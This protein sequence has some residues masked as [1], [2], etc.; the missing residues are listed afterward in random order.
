MEADPL[1]VLLGQFM[2]S[3][4]EQLPVLI[5]HNADMIDDKF[6]QYIEDKINASNDLEE[7]DSLRTLRDAITDLYKKML[8]DMSSAEAAAAAESGG[9]S[10]SEKNA[11][12]DAAYDR[13]IDEMVSTHPEG[14]EPLAIAVQLRYDRIDM[15]CLERLEARIGAVGDNAV[16]AAPLIAV[17]EAIVKEMNARVKKAAERVKDVLAARDMDAMRRKLSELARKGGL[18]DAFTLLLKGNMDQARKAGN[19]QA[20]GALSLLLKYA[21]EIREAELDPEVRLIRRLLREENGEVRAEMLMDSFA[22]KKGVAMVDGSTTSG[23]RVDG[24]RFVK[25]LRGLLEEY[26]NV[27]KDFVQKLSQIGAESEAVARKIYDME[28]KDIKELQDEAFHKRS[29]SIWDLEKVEVAEEMEGRKAGW[30]G[31]LGSVPPGFD[32]KG[33]MVI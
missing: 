24:K 2:Y 3:P 16:A 32:E 8:E 12:V 14:A 20:V 23:V 25:A 4:P 29:V 15:R 6:Y 30:E 19:A 18:D 1:D 7:R 11:E 10:A 9:S 27:D 17:R 26:G 31:K 22:P 21:A 13:L 33:K 5:Q 28:G